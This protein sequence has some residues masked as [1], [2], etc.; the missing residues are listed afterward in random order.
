MAKK[1]NFGKIISATGNEYVTKAGDL[2]GIIDEWISSNSYALNGLIGGSIFKGIPNNRSV[3]FAGIE[4]VGKSLFT[5]FICIQAMSM[6]YFPVYFDTEGAVDEDTFA[7]SGKVKGVDYEILPVKT[8]DDL[9]VQMYKMIDEYKEY[10]DSLNDEEYP[11][12]SKLLFVIDSIG[13]LTSAGNIKNLEKGEVKRDMSKQQSLRELF[14]DVTMD[15]GR[16]KIPLIPVNHVYET[17]DPYGEKFKVSGGGGARYGASSII[18]LAK[19]KARDKD[20]KQ[21]GVIITATA[22]KSRFVREGS[23]V[24][25]YLDF[26]KGLQPYYGLD[27]FLDDGDIL[28]KK[29]GKEEYFM[30]YKGK[31]EKGEYPTL[32]GSP[33]K[34]ENRAIA[35]EIL[36]LIDKKVQET[37]GFGSDGTSSEDDDYLG[38]ETSIGEE[39]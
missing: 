23:K 24:E 32:V 37:F 15:M 8:I 2:R 19:K 12:R 7:G 34:K 21:I 9:R 27:Q 35:E 20:K 31:D 28:E 33:W 11:K 14:R 39:E 29:R 26:Q 16:L 4:A 1:F 38:E 10:Y 25:I 17:I 5:K 18:T 6:G 22:A 3:M 30:I 36:P 13:M